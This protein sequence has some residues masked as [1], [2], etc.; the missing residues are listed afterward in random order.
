ML[1]I[2]CRRE[3]GGPVFI[4]KSVIPMLFLISLLY[5]LGPVYLL[6]ALTVSRL[7]PV[8]MIRL[9]LA[10]RF[11]GVGDRKIGS[12]CYQAFLLIIT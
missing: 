5:I 9:I 10:H 1:S 11:F 3:W 6:D 12:L 4:W 2:A 7:R 8:I